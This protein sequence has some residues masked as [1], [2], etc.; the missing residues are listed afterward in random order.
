[1]GNISNTATPSLD[2][3]IFSKTIETN[4]TGTMLC[5]RAVTNI[6]AAQELLTYTSRHGTRSLGRGS[7]INLGSANSYI[8]APNMMP[9]VASKHAIIGITK[10]AGKQAIRSPHN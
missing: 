4:I 5:I 3:D 10:S 2:V 1:M 7:I 6:M 9:Y 8:A